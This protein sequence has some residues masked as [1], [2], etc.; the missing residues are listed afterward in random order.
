MKNFATIEQCR[1]LMGFLDY[2]TADMYY[3]MYYP[4][5]PQTLN[6]PTDKEYFE[7]MNRVP[8]WSLGKLLDIIPTHIK[9]RGFQPQSFEDDLKNRYNIEFVKSQ[10]KKDIVNWQIKYGNTFTFNSNWEEIVSSI[11]SEN[12]IDC[13]V[14]MLQWLHENN[15]VN[16]Y[17][18]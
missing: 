4:I 6:K 8:C 18:E 15:F 1:I 11:Q 17:N 9:K 14:N 2:E 5:H 12:L 10:Y 7:S 16:Y 13:I 3:S